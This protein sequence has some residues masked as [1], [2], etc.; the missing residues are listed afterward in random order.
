MKKLSLDLDKLEVESFTTAGEAKARGTVRGQESWGEVSAMAGVGCY[1]GHAWCSQ[2]YHSIAT[3]C[4]KCGPA[5][6]E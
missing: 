4:L 6:M 1:T 3:D 2:D 5:T